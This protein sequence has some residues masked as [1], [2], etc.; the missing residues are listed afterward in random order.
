MKHVSGF[1]VFCLYQ[2]LKLHFSGNYD[3]IKYNMKPPRGCNA[4]K[5]AVWRGKGAAVKI[6]YE[7]QLDEKVI[8][9]MASNLVR[10]PKS[11]I[12]DLTGE[13]P[14]ARYNEARS[15]VSNPAL[16]VRNITTILKDSDFQYN[17]ESGKYVMDL[18]MNED[19][20][21]LELICYIYKMFPKIYN[22]MTD[23]SISAMK[24]DLEFRIKK[25]SPFLI[26]NSPEELAAIRAQILTNLISKQ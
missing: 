11:W 21:S 7:Y 12:L 1:D 10:E 15:L 13:E 3:A 14:K 20:I 22:L 5:Y 26:I 16:L 18:S 8:L 24:D 2:T 6:A 9:A 17:C 4:D 19:D 23:S 25:Y